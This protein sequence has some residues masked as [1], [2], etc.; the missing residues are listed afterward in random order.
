[1][2]RENAAGKV[3]YLATAEPYERALPTLRGYAA[4]LLDTGYPR[5]ELYANFER[6]RGV[7][8]GRRRAHSARGGAGCSAG[9]SGEV[10]VIK[11][12]F[13]ELKH[14]DGVLGQLCWRLP[15]ADLKVREHF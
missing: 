8:A 1:M 5:D 15:L 11:Y 2:K 12:C 9:G 4:A 6:A 13:S 3:A 10:G 14:A 7:L